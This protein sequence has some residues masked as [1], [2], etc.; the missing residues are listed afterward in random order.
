MTYT[1]MWQYIYKWQYIYNSSWYITAEAKHIFWFSL[2]TFNSIFDAVSA[3]IFQGMF[4][5]ICISSADKLITPDHCFD[6]PSKNY[7]T[8]VRGNLT[9]VLHEGVNGPRKPM[10][11]CDRT[12]STYR[13]SANSETRWKIKLLP[14]RLRW[15]RIHRRCLVNLQLDGNIRN[16]WNASPI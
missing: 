16:Q 10:Q 13:N 4:L 5:G 12:S 15:I 1:P 7:W 6:A 8:D 9:V 14:E 3:G 2:L 11:P